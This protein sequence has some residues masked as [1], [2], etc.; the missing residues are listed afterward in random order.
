MT[1]HIENRD[2]IIQSLREELV[3]P[4]PQGKAINCSGEITFNSAQEGFYGPWIQDNGEEILQRDS[5]TIRY[6]VGV[7][8]S[9]NTKLEN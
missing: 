3:G 2:K 9:L 4:S 7:L 1:K 5:P 6:G 8:Y